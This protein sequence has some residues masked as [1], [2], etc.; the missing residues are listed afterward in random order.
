[1]HR[2]ALI[3]AMAESVEPI[4][5]AFSRHWPEAI[6]FDLLDT[7][8]APDLLH[9]DESHSEMIKRFQTLGQYAAASNGNGG[10]TQGI[11][12]TCSAFRTEIDAV[13]AIVNIPVLGPS[14]SAFNNALANSKRIG[15][16]VTFEPS[17][18]VLE[19]ELRLL[20]KKQGVNP[21][22]T[23]RVVKGALNALKSGDASTHDDLIAEAAAEMT[24]VDSLILGQFSMARA[25]A[26][27]PPLPGREVLTTPASAVRQ[28][29]NIIVSGSV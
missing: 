19:Q 8:L 16:L 27:I 24:E 26:I 3:H 9:V 22:I 15:L 20:A 1:M 5:A 21:S 6:T 2:I 11:L 17:L 28:L 23:C 29:R 25:G 7:S 12:F 14:E 10:D 4:H 13:K 18:A